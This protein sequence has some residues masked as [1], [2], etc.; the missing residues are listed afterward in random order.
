MA[1][2]HNHELEQIKTGALDAELEKEIT[3]ALGGKS[4]E[5]I[6]TSDASVA[7][8][9]APQPA[10]GEGQASA[11][12][13]QETRTG[14]IAAVRGDDVFVEFGG[15]DQG[16]CPL[17]QFKKAP[18]V[19]DRME[20]VIQ[21]YMPAEGLLK[22]GRIGG[23]AKATWETL[24]KGMVVEAMVTGANTGGLELKV[25]GQRAFMPA[26]QIDTSHVEN[27]AGYINQKLRCQV[28][29]LDK[30]KKRV[31]L[32]RRAVLV[33][34]EEAKK[35]ELL[36]TLAV[37]QIFDGKVRS[38]KP[39]GVF[40]NIGGI[41]GLVHIS[42]M[43]YTRLKNPDQV[44]KPGDIVKVVILAIDQE[45]GKLSLGMKQVQPDPWQGV[46]ER[47]PAGT[48]LTARVVRLA[49][50]GVFVELETGVE[51][52]VPMGELSWTHVRE[53]GDVLRENQTA[54]FKVLSV[55]PEQKR[56]SLSHK[57]VTV[58][59]WTQADTK[60]AP[61]AT[62]KGKVVRI[63]QFGA[64]VELEPGIEGMIHISQLSDKRVGR[65]EDV[66][67][68]GQEVEARVTEFDG[69]KHRVGLSI[70]ALTA[71]DSPGENSGEGG[72]EQRA[73]RE[74]IRKYV[75]KE[76]EIKATESLG[77]LL[78]KFGGSGGLK[79]GIG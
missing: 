61:G 73:S 57:Q 8:S 31:V 54:R 48:E 76:K 3:D 43:S 7:A 15:K 55:D 68:E 28:V 11:S 60:Y 26:S 62:V 72:G 40:V 65:V 36:K 12:A 27:F 67:K 74:D 63:A 69:A 1:G 79:G 24:F 17:D 41:D 47:Y 53:A 59:P 66:V 14:T 42:D 58:D 25:A 46:L 45:T 19:G 38:S 10:E 39:Y 64:F 22:L 23:A 18:R 6:M 20:F 4:V 32:S 77:A 51:G 13:G 78:K 75:R 16:V 30:A 34:E 71:G 70:R 49:P 5:E 21:M 29:E 2:Q 50:F 33:V 56:V 35:E 37:G 9:A 52:L 44:A